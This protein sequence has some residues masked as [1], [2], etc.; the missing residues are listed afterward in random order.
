MRSKSA[1]Q[2]LHAADFSD[3]H[4][5]T[6]GII[7]YE[8]GKATGGED[9]GMDFFIRGDFNDVFRMSYAMEKGLQQLYLSLEELCDDE[10]VKKLLSRLAKFE[11]G[12]KAKL[13]AMFPDIPREEETESDNLEEGFTRQQVLDNFK[14]S[15][16]TVDGIIHLGMA[17]E[18]QAYDLYS[19]LSA[20]SD[21]KET[22]E[23]FLFMVAEEKQHLGFLSAEYDKILAKRK[24]V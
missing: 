21:N 3:I 22:K 17:I 8:G 24:S 10:S 23:F 6:G 2:L 9:F 20:S 19:R 13:K 5:V 16:I 4:N 11:E 1:A 7:V 14:T 18:T 15:N 12:H